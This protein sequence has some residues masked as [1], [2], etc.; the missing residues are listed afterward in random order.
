MLQD[1]VVNAIRAI[2]I[3]LEIGVLVKAVC[4]YRCGVFF[5]LKWVVLEMVAVL[6]VMGLVEQV[7]V[8]WLQSAGRGGHR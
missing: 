1:H 2:L 4:K 8:I 7:L 5:R 3:L 6:L